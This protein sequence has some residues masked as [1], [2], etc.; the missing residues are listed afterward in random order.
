MFGRRF[1]LAN[2]GSD[3]K[4]RPLVGTWQ[5]GGSKFC[6]RP[7]TS[8]SFLPQDE[9]NQVMTTNVWLDQ[10]WRDELLVWDPKDFGGI[11]RI[12]IPCDRIWLPDI[13]LYN[14]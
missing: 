10:E 14:K 8:L 7:F 12:R 9:K 1:P 13:V 11:D 6:A 4:Q 5:A 3:T 2:V